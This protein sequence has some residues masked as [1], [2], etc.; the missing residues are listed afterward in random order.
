MQCWTLSGTSEFSGIYEYEYV[1]QCV[2]VGIVKRWKAVCKHCTVQML[3]KQ[4]QCQ[5]NGRSNVEMIHR[6]GIVPFT[7]GYQ[8]KALEDALRRIGEGKVFRRIGT[9]I[10]E[11]QCNLKLFVSLTAVYAHTILSIPN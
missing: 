6:N 10:E 7:V 4:T 11:L 3:L 5:L 8:M 9:H 2:F 1:F